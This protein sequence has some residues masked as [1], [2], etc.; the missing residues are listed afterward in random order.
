M[1]L[2]ICEN[3]YKVHPLLSGTF[4]RSA[5]KMFSSIIFACGGSGVSK[6]DIDTRGGGTAASQYSCWKRSAETVS[7]RAV[8][9]S[10]VI[11]Y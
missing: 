3:S 6:R 8:L 4:E 10:T 1:Y 5:E 2:V 9:G 7:M 11:H